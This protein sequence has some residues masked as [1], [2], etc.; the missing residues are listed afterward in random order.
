MADA[1]SLLERV[2]SSMATGGGSPSGKQQKSILSQA[3]A[4]FARRPSAAE[5]TIPTGFDPVAATLFESVVEAAFLVATADGEFDQAERNIFETVVHESCQNTIQRS[6][7]TELVSDLMDQLHED[8][9]DKRIRMV[10]II[11]Q[12][13]EHKIEVLRIAALMAHVSGG[14][15]H[16]ERT[17][18]EKL[19]AQFGLPHGVVQTVL[20]QASTALG[21]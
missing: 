21:R 10:G 17:V 11:V 12:S 19:C 8:G 13:D 18:M 6:E 1:D 9:L 16:T 20:D 14:V 3:A 15:H 7:V 5:Q 2:V 4:S